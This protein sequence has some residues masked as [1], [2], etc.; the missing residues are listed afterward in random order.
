MNLK[1]LKLSHGILIDVPNDMSVCFPSLKVLHLMWVE[2]AN[3]ESVSNLFRG[4][5]VLEELVI[6]RFSEY[7]VSKFIISIH[8]LK[9]LS[10]IV[11]QE[12]NWFDLAKRGHE[13][14]IDAPNLKYLQLVNVGSFVHFESVF[15]SLNKANIDFNG[16]GLFQV[17]KTLC[18]AQFLSLEWITCGNIMASLKEDCF[19]WFHNLTQ[20]KLQI[21]AGDCDVIPLFLE[22]SPNLEVLFVNKIN[23]RSSSTRERGCVLKSLSPHLRQVYD[24]GFQGHVDEIEMVEFILKKSSAL[25]LF[26]ICCYGTSKELKYRILKRLSM[27]PRASESC[28]LIFEPE[29]H[30]RKNCK[31]HEINLVFDLFLA[32]I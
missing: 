32:L 13:L 25:E 11:H 28:Q 24:G 21:D 17:A 9:S 7:Y 18:N 16:I 3:N 30:L 26:E 23:V 15:T 8:T 19:P 29:I 20:L 6:D 5:T 14:K 27:F 1:V 10:Y 22:N 12:E 4:C 2:Y 31:S